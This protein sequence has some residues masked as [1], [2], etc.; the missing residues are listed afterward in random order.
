MIEMADK[1]EHNPNGKVKGG[2]NIE[3]FVRLMKEIGLVE[4]K[5]DQNNKNEK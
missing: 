4:P 1:P 3:D 5:M 2:A